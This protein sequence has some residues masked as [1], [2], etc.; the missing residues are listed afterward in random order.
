MRKSL[1][2]EREKVIA[3][4]QVGGMLFLCKLKE[5]TVYALLLLILSWFVALGIYGI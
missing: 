5:D 2:A 3:Y 1:E 4:A